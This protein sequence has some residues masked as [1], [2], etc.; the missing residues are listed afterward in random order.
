MQSTGSPLLPAFLAT[1]VSL[2]ITDQRAIAQ[3]GLSLKGVPV[4]EPSNLAEF[5]TNRAAAVALGKAFFWDMQMGSD[6]VTACATCHFNAGADSRWRN[7]IS[8]GLQRVDPN[9][10]PWKDTHFDRG[11]NWTLTPADFPLRFLANPDDRNSMVLRDTNDVVGSQG[12]FFTEFKKV[13]PGKFDEKT[14]SSPDPDGFRIGHLNVRRVEPR[15]TP[16]VINAV[17][18]SRNFWDGRA[19]ALFNGV[20]HMG[21]AD[22]DARVYRAETPNHLA[23]VRVLLN[24]ASLASQAVA[25]PLNAMEMS[26]EGRTFADIFDKFGTRNKGLGK[27]ARGLRPLGAQLVHP[28]DSVLG[29]FSRWPQ[30][31]LTI[32]TYEALIRAAFHPRWWQSELTIRI[33]SKGLHSIAANGGNSGKFFSQMEYNFAMFFGLAIQMYEA[34]LVSDDSP[35]DRAAAIPAT[36]QLTLQQQQGFALFADTVRVRC[37][38]CHTGPEMTDAATGRIASGGAFRFREGQ[39]ID[40]GFNNI[41]LRP[42]LD[43]LGVGGADAEGRPLAL[44]RRAGMTNIAVDGAFK[45]PGLRNVELTAPYFHNGGQLTLR[46]VVEFYNRGGDFL[47]SHGREGPIAGLNQGMALSP[48]EKEALVAFLLSLTDERVRYRRAPF[49]HPQL[50]APNGAVTFGWMLMEGEKG[51]VMDAFLEIPAVGRRGG[52]PLRKFLE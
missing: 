10:G 37:I 42:T 33:D 28:E 8:P 36:A 3:Q 45:A 44:T 31:G 25:P 19:A 15:N 34:T 16:T 18:N 21:E 35:F 29:S 41:G 2:A 23:A 12:V 7:Q 6:N 43:D 32:A 9:Y 11:P 38:N 14:K 52:P 1:F 50:F 27:K 13:T 5:V 4:P 49:D 48:I 30:P 20:N 17:F 26:A 39:W 40:R 47:P 24:N 22:P 46:G 51:Q